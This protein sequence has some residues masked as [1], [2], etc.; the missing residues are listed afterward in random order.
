MIVRLSR[1][2]MG[3]RFLY[4]VDR[5]CALLVVA[6]ASDRSAGFRFMWSISW[7]SHHNNTT[8]LCGAHTCSMRWQYMTILD[9]LELINWDA[10]RTLF[11]DTRCKHGKCIGT[12]WGS[13][14]GLDGIGDA[15]WFEKGDIFSSAIQERGKLSWES[16]TK[17]HSLESVA[18]ATTKS[19]FVI[20]LI[21][22][23]DNVSA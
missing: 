16:A 17:H 20:K 23:N 12:T 2:T 3:C 1:D 19:T 10:L 13:W 4:V 5:I 9:T 7:E 6:C 8:R 14:R 15:C 11:S 21:Y 22:L 18:T